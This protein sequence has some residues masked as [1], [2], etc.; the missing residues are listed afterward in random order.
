M[1][2]MW[3][4]GMSLRRITEWVNQTHG[5]T[6]SQYDSINIHLATEKPLKF[7]FDSFDEFR[8]LKTPLTL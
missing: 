3:R 8:K 6:M 5:I 7:D 2:D 1:K 4:R